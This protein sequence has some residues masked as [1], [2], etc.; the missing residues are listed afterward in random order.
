MLLTTE[1]LFIY[2]RLLK[3]TLNASY[4]EYL[5]EYPNWESKSSDIAAE[6]I[7]DFLGLERYIGSEDIGHAIDNNT[8]PT[9]ILDANIS[10]SYYEQFQSFTL[11]PSLLYELCPR[12]PG[13][14]NS[15]KL[16]N[17]IMQGAPKLILPSFTKCR[18]CTGMI[19][20]LDDLFPNAKEKADAEINHYFH[21]LDPR[22][23]SISYFFK[24]DY[25]K[26]NTLSFTF[27]DKL[28]ES[29][30]DMQYFCDRGNG[31]YNNNAKLIRIISDDNLLHELLT[32]DIQLA[33][34]VCANTLRKLNRPVDSPKEAS[35]VL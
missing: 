4:V 20:R 32:K 1:I 22:R 2:K 17:K 19:R 9:T 30:E 14:S 16:V 35:F 11:T 31:R 21:S 27:V 10:M 24:N 26:K 34:Y 6:E 5:K 25:D 15:F 3:F 23:L 8:S 28:D 33:K 7:L 18:Q 13:R 12:Y 29:L